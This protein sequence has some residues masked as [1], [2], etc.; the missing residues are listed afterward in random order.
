MTETFGNFDDIWP[1]MFQSLW[2][3]REEEDTDEGGSD[4]EDTDNENADEEIDEDSLD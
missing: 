1:M 2:L 4:N 3:A